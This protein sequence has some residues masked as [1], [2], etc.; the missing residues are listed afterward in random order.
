V[1]N[2]GV[3]E[4]KSLEGC[5][6]CNV[7]PGDK[8]QIAERTVIET[9]N[10][11]VFPT[12]GQISD[13]GY[14][15]MVPKEHYSC[16]GEMPEPMI[17]ELME[18]KKEVD[19]RITENYSEPMYFEHGG[20]GQTVFHSHL[21]AIPTKNPFIARHVANELID[22]F[23]RK[24]VRTESLKDLKDVWKN[25]GMYVYFESHDH[26][27]GVAVY[28]PAMPMYARIVIADKMGVP[29]RA[30][31]RTMDRAL[32]DRLIAETLQKLK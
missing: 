25:H 6:F 18:L 5:T 24:F 2:E 23:H 16:I 12:L 26:E 29:E 10:F 9:P 4:M 32:D 19:K 31:W 22:K 8:A 27:W 14:L 3:V 30:N 15:L 7:K 17:D 28:T 11:R 13:G 20:L 1:V 21:H